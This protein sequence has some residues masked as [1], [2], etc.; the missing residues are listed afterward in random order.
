[1]T[2]DDDFLII[3]TKLNR[4]PVTS[5][6]VPRAA[7]LARLN[8]NRERPL[9]LVIAPAGYGKSTLLSSWLDTIGEQRTAWLSLDADDNDLSAFLSYFLAAVQTIFPHAGQET[10]ALLANAIDIP[11]WVLNATLI[12]ELNRI[13]HDYILIL[14]DFHLIQDQDVHQFMVELLDHA[15]QT[16]HLVIASRTDPPLPV[17]RYRAKNRVA[18][19]RANDLRFSRAETS[20]FLRQSLGRPLDHQT[21]ANIYNRSEGWVTGLRLELLSARLTKQHVEEDVYPNNAYL[22][23]YLMLEALSSLEEPVRE[24]LVKSAVLNRFCAG[25]CDAVCAADGEDPSTTFNGAVFLEKLVAANLF[26]IPLDT[27]HTWYRYHHLFALFLQQLLQNQYTTAEIG[28]LRQKASDWLA[29]NGFGKEAL[30]QAIAANDINRATALIENN[31][32]KLLNED[33]WHALK[34]WLNELPFARTQHSPKLLLAH[35]WVAYFQHKLEAIPALL[36]VIESLP[37]ADTFDA[38]TKG[39]IDFFRGQQLYWKGQGRQ[40]IPHLQ[41][42]LQHIPREY[43]WSRASAELFFAMAQYINGREEEAVSFLHQALCEYPLGNL[44]E[45]RLLATLVFIYLLAGNLELAEQTNHRVFQTARKMNSTYSLA[46]AFYLQAFIRLERNQQD[47]AL[48][49]FKSVQEMRY[50]VSASAAADGLAGLALLYQAKGQEGQADGVVA[51]MQ[52]LALETDNEALLMAARSCQARLAVWRGDRETA[53]RWL[54]TADLPAPRG[55]MVFWLE[56]P[57]ITEC[58]VLIAAGSDDD[59]ALASEKLAQYLQENREAHNVMRQIE[60]LILQT[61]VYLKQ[62]QLT[63]AASVLEEAIT[64]AMP[65]GWLFPFLETKK[66]LVPLLETLRRQNVAPDYTGRILDALAQRNG[67]KQ[68]Q[69]TAVPL[70]ATLTYREGDV[71][72]LLAQGMSNREIANALTISPNTVKRHTGSLYRKLAVKNRRQAV[73]KAQKIGLLPPRHS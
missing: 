17:A 35:A 29:G 21:V 5:D 24:W 41:K 8:E 7:L 47:A 15:P 67:Q 65:G 28:R 70:T 66:A 50:H 30:H 19:I 10:A 60:L 39:E 52:I 56:I 62:Q 46:W 57:H 33:K 13:T 22:T 49:D 37:D 43:A 68:E 26:I 18:D 25:L 36:Q 61:V 53:V 40:S 55:L 27:H 64:L 20:A 23:D 9:T 3:R 58:R 38:A 32:H 63:A 69:E 4:P 44:R 48:D 11:T 73:I 31:R 71:L 34:Q 42:A 72:D 51:Q 45:S 1:V 16:L 2:T 12:N 14:D 59:L 6:L 54:H